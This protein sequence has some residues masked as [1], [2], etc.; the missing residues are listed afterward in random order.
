MQF[1]GESSPHRAT[2]LSFSVKPFLKGLRRSNARALVAVRRRR[3]SLS[4]KAPRKGE[5]Q[6]V[7]LAEGNHTSGGFP[8]LRKGY[9]NCLSAFFFGTR[10][11]RKKLGKKETPQERF[12][13]LR[14]ATN[15]TRV[16][17]APPFREKV[18][19]NNSGFAVANSSP[20][21]NLKN[22]LI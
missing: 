21:Q 10:G 9:L 3:N 7:G 18:D 22:N 20:N 6:A 8:F 1:I 12:R 2:A 15:A 13:R 19:E 16:G 5:C 4:F 11:A 17:S 14:T